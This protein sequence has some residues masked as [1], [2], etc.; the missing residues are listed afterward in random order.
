MKVLYREG[1][2]L[3]ILFLLFKINVQNVKQKN[4][5]FHKLKVPW[6]TIGDVSVTDIFAIELSVSVDRRMDRK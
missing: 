5:F 3:Q 6:F 1:I 2:Y 4:S